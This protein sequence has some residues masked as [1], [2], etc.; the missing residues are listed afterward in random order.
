MT[1]KKSIHSA[2]LPVMANIAQSFI[3]L[4]RIVVTDPEGVAPPP[5]PL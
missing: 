1:F 4:E 2:V 5:S 3:D